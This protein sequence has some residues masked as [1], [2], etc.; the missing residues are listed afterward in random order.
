MTMTSFTDRPVPRASFRRL[1]T[2]LRL[3]RFMRSARGVAAIEFAGIFPLFA[4]L[5]I[6]GISMG[7]AYRYEEKLNAAIYTLGDMTS[8]EVD[9]SNSRLNF[10][11]ETFTTIM[12]DSRSQYD[13]TITSVERQYDADTDTWSIIPRW[14]YDSTTNTSINT[15][16]TVDESLVPEVADNETVLLIK[17]TARY[18]IFLNYL[19]QG[20]STF[21]RRTN[22]SPRDTLKIANL[23]APEV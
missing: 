23:D 12:N 18:S 2:R 11:V 14:R 20:E 22:V 8:R 3:G 19:K 15:G 10:L 17:V 6:G 7:D 9:T 16:I 4:A 21:E 1:V 13:I 5:F